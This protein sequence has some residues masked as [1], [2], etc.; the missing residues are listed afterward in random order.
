MKKHLPPLRTIVFYPVDPASG[1]YAFG[2]P[3]VHSAVLHLEKVQRF[4]IQVKNQSA[5]N[6]YVQ[7]VTIN[8]QKLT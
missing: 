8:G 6:V 2:S 7:Q 4:T 5:K 1:Q 3:L